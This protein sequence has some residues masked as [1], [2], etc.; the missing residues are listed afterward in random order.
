MATEKTFDKADLLRFFCE[1]EADALVGKF[2]V[3]Y[4]PTPTQ[5]AFD[6]DAET[7][8]T[9][10]YG[11]AAETSALYCERY[12]FSV[13]IQS[14]VLPDGGRSTLPKYHPPRPT[15]TGSRAATSRTSWRPSPGPAQPSTTKAGGWWC[16]VTRRGCC[17]GR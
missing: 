6:G 2:T 10:R 11:V 16:A 5:L 13:V 4:P 14:V 17:N 7:G 8:E 3:I 1:A 9:L 12:G 15:A